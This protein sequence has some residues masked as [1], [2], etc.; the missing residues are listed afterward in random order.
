MCEAG[1]ARGVSL[2]QIAPVSCKGLCAGAGRAAGK[3]AS[4]GRTSREP[5]SRVTAASRGRR[6]QLGPVSAKVEVEPA[7]RKTRTDAVC[8]M[9]GER[10][11]T[12]AVPMMRQT[13]PPVRQAVERRHR[14]DT[15]GEPVEVP[16][17]FGG[18]HRLERFRGRGVV[19]R[20]VPS[21]SSMR[22]RW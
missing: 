15:A 18:E 7:V 16:R 17:Q 4:S 10:D 13:S 2:R 20:C 12:P 8:P 21:S 14:F 5:S 9:R 3:A 1:V 11:L 6:I 22:I 19:R